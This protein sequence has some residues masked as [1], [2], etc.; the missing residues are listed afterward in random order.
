M[1][2]RKTLK[3][4]INKDNATFSDMKKLI[5][6]VTESVFKKTGISIEKEI[7]ILEN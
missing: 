5:D 7:K 4:F 1:Y 6:F 3:F 2:F